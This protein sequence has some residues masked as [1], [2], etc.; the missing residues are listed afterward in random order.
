MGEKWLGKKNAAIGSWLV[1]VSCMVFAGG[2]GDEFGKINPKAPPETAQFD[3][4]TGEWR[5][6]I[7]YK[8]PSGDYMEYQ[9][10]FRCFWIVDGFVL[11]QDWIGPYAKGSEFRAYDPS[12][13]KWRGHNIY[14]GSDCKTTEGEFKDGNMIMYILDAKDRTGEFINRETYYDITETSFKMKSDRS[15]D[16]GKTWGEGAYSMKGSRI[17]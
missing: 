17:K 14:A 1:L 12:K 16:G 8:R 11:Q 2:S 3:F 13:K 15:Y 10:T 4:M 7:K 9:A 5:V 6:D